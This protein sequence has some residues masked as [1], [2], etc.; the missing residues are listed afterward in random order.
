MHVLISLI[1]LLHYISYL[2]INFN[3]KLKMKASG[4]IFSH[5]QYFSTYK[6]VNARVGRVHSIMSPLCAY[7]VSYHNFIMSLSTCNLSIRFSMV[8]SI[9][10]RSSV[11]R[12]MYLS[13]HTTIEVSHYT[14]LLQQLILSFLF[15]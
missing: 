10:T 11:T 3:I 7:T 15:S 12:N 4:Y 2:F 9:I 5:S 8:P 13:S 14:L 1:T 6:E